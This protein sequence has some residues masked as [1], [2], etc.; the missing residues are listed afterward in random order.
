MGPAV[1]A[2]A[3]AGLLE[4]AGTL[5]VA[6]EVGAMLPRLGVAP[7]LGSTEGTEVYFPTDAMVGLAVAGSS[8]N[9]S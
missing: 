9:S 6:L 1:G 4:R 2:P 7:Q 3:P 8:T 5:G